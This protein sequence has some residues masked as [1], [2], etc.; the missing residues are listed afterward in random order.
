MS[1]ILA[2]RE[3]SAAPREEVGRELARRAVRSAIVAIALIWLVAAGI[4][5]GIRASTPTVASITSFA[6]QHS[7]EGKSATDRARIS[8]RLARQIA[9]LD[10]WQQRELSDASAMRQFYKS[11]TSAEKERFLQLTISSAM[12]NAFRATAATPSAEREGFMN[13]AFY[14]IETT[15]SKDTSAPVNERRVE[16]WI[17]DAAREAFFNTPLGLRMELKPIIDR[18][19]PGYLKQR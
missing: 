18:N 9:A 14:E 4:L 6:S 16:D 17:R 1:S 15:F 2:G 8:A 12:R 10:Y 3:A 7:L 19:M 13:R 5:V 11:F